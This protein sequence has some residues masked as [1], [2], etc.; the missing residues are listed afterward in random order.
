MLFYCSME[1]IHIHIGVVDKLL[2]SMEDML[3]PTE[4]QGLLFMDNF[5]K[6]V[7]CHNKQIFNFENTA[8]ATLLIKGW[9]IRSMSDILIKLQGEVKKTLRG[10]NAL[11]IKNY[12]PSPY[13]YVFM[14]HLCLL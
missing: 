7:G 13:L 14:C 11:Y 5:L 10:S 6:K 8:L 9:R 12:K 1:N 4:E 2:K 3:F